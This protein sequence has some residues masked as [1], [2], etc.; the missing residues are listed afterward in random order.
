MKVFLKVLQKAFYRLQKGEL[1]VCFISEQLE[2]SGELELMAA[3][4]YSINT[5]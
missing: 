3:R 2:N 1:K 5:Q 4:Q